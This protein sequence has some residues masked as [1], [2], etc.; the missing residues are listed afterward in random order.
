MFSRWEF[1]ISHSGSCPFFIK[2]KTS[3]QVTSTL[4]CCYLPG[5]SVFSSYVWVSQWTVGIPAG[6]TQR[7][8]RQGNLVSL[9]IWPQTEFRPELMHS[10]PQSIF[11][12]RK[13]LG[14]KVQAVQCTKTKRKASCFFTYFQYEKFFPSDT[15]GLKSLHN[16]HALKKRKFNWFIKQILFCTKTIIMILI[17]YR[18]LINLT[19]GWVN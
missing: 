18:L 15:Q 8:P 9:E 13:K 19:L 6:L 7:K 16:Q 5:W 10:N 12:T 3:K 14:L 11:F 4:M 17:S 1:S 2:E